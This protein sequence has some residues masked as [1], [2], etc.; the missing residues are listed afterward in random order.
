MTDTL[1]TSHRSPTALVEGVG[2]EEHSLRN[3]SE[4]PTRQ[5]GSGRDVSPSEI[6]PV[7]NIMRTLINTCQKNKHVEMKKRSKQEELR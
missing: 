2:V 5:A 3:Q 7:C 6:G 1:G 4:G